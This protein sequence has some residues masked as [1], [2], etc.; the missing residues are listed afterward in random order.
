M[1]YYLYQ[2]L[3]II[4]DIL[5]FPFILL[6]SLHKKQ[7]SRLSIQLPSL[8]DSIWFHAASLGEVNALKPLIIKTIEEYKNSHIVLTTMTETGQNAALQI[9]DKLIVTYLPIDLP[10]PVNRFLKKINPYILIIME[11]E[12]WPQ[13]L[14]Q[15]GKKKIPILLVNARLSEKSCHS[16]ERTMYFWKHFFCYVSGVNSQSEA[17]TERFLK[18]GFRDVN[19]T[20]NLKLAVDLPEYDHNELRREWGYK[21]D[22][23]VVVFGSSRP[24]EELLMSTMINELQNDISKLK[25]IIV[26]RHLKRLNEVTD[27]FSK[28]EPVLYSE[29]ISASDNKLIII[30]QMGILTK[31]YALADIA[32]VGGSFADFGGHNPLEAAYYGIPVI[33]G[34]YHYSCRNSVELLKAHDAIIISD[35]EDLKDNIIKLFED[36]KL[37]KDMG[38]RAQVMLKANSHALERNLLTIRKLVSDKLS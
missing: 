27:I 35:S 20:G 12:L 17:D 16:Y 6:L 5:V 37:R 14:S 15:T 24:G 8:Q 22:D 3:L 31:L 33:M 2:F 21:D 29:K 28:F 4:I 13:I 11:T 25:L 32:L 38:N 18:L 19:D 36:N 26:P 23:F 34:K 10:V 7:L 1:I 9:S 30:D